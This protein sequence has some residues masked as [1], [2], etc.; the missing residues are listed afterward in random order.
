MFIFF[1]IQNFFCN[2]IKLD[3]GEG[4]ILSLLTKMIFEKFLCCDIWSYFGDFRVFER[5][6][7]PDDLILI[8]QL[9]GGCCYYSNVCRVLEMNFHL[10]MIVVKTVDLFWQLLNSS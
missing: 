7:I 9:D 3:K 10:M 2:R 6:E 8:L 5:S 1:K 4:S